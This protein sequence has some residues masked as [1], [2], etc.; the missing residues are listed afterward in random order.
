MQLIADF[1]LLLFF[2][3]KHSKLLTQRRITLQQFKV[4]QSQLVLTRISLTH[5][6]SLNSWL[7]TYRFSHFD[8]FVHYFTRLQTNHYTLLTISPISSSFDSAR[9]LPYHLLWHFVK[10]PIAWQDWRNTRWEKWLR[11]GLPNV[12][13]TRL[14][15]LISPTVFRI[16][17]NLTI[18]VYSSLAIHPAWTTLKKAREH[19]KKI[20]YTNGA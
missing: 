4:K 2:Y 19:N 14:V 1:H 16:F 10:I 15:S 6:P 11:D 5:Q 3:T 20:R 12:I 7:Y 18:S 13:Y 9:N 17:V 8:M